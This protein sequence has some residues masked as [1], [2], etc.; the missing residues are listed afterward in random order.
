MQNTF[1]YISQAAEFYDENDVDEIWMAETFLRSFAA[2]GSCELS[3]KFGLELSFERPY[4]ISTRQAT[5]SR[6]QSRRFCRFSPR[7]HPTLFSTI[8]EAFP[9]Y[10]TI[11]F[12]QRSQIILW[13]VGTSL[14]QLAC[15][16]AY[17]KPQLVLSSRTANAFN[18]YK[19]SMRNAAARQG[20]R[21][22]P[23][24]FDLYWQQNVRRYVPPSVIPDLSHSFLNRWP[25]RRSTTR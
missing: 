20:L 22:V 25:Y 17:V 8:T 14:V 6:T 16:A 23:P 21:S 1:D 2:L 13:V 3:F 24:C 18:Y 9:C 4:Q 11:G 15:L 10:S 7:S 5:S 19:M 12:L